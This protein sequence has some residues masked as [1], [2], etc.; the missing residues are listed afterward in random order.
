MIDMPA[1]F[2]LGSTVYSATR[3]YADDDSLPLGGVVIDIFDR[4][5]VTTGEKVPCA[6]TVTLYRG[7]VRYQVLEVSDLEPGGSHGLIRTDILKQLA[8]QLAAD[9][10]KQKAPFLHDDARRAIRRALVEHGAVSA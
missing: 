4:D 10:V 6:K 5:D 9:E 1:A 3:H 8:N 7:Q 2:Q